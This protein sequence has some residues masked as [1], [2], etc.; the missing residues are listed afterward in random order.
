MR[1]IVVTKKCE[2]LKAADQTLSSAAQLKLLTIRTELALID[3][4]LRQ[5][6]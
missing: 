1:N 2:A 3:Q 4:S 5:L 6:Q